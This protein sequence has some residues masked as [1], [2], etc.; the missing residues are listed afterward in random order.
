MYWPLIGGFIGVLLLTL[1]IGFIIDV[2]RGN[3]ADRH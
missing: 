3:D 2:S 1:L